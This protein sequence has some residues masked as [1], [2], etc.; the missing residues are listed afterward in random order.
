VEPSQLADPKLFDF[1]GLGVNKEAV[2]PSQTQ[3]QTSPCG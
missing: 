3:T 2:V 1:L